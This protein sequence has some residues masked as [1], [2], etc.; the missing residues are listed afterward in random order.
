MIAKT[1]TQQ[2]ATT[3]RWVSLARPRPPISLFVF[4]SF[5]WR[6]MSTDVSTWLRVFFALQA[7]AIAS[8]GFFEVSSDSDDAA[9]WPRTSGHDV[10]GIAAVLDPFL[11]EMPSSFGA[12]AMARRWLAIVEGLERLALVDPR[13]EYAENRSLWRALPAVCVYLANT[14]TTF[15]SNHPTVDGAEILDARA[16]AIELYK[17]PWARTLVMTLVTQLAHLATR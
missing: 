4:V 9:R 12:H 17:H 1:A 13:A 6:I 15:L 8:R 5:Q 10:I 11:R 7:S 14:V 2:L 16:I 3:Q